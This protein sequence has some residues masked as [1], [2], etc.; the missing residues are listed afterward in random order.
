M[1]LSLSDIQLADALLLQFCK[2]V[3]HMY[4]VAIITPNMH[5]NYAL[6]LKQCIL[7]YG[8]IYVFWFFFFER[9]IGSFPTSIAVCWKCNAC[10]GLYES[11]LYIIL[12]HEHLSDFSTLFQS[13]DPVVQG[14]IAANS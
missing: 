4:G 5:N 11:L 6:H 3:E 2:R 7:D 1:Q 10:R 8:S 14:S 9:Y 13:I 12:P